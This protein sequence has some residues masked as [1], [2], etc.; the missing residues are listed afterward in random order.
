LNAVQHAVQGGSCTSFTTILLFR[1][2]SHAPRH[3]EGKGREEGMLVLEEEKKG[4]EK[5]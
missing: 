1:S 3:P 5:E 4:K 2:Y